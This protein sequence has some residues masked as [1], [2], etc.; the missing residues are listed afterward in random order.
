MLSDEDIEKIADRQIQGTDEGVIVNNGVLIR[1][2]KKGFKA[3]L[4]NN[5]TNSK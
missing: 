2:F 5:Q 1:W 4:Q 3:A